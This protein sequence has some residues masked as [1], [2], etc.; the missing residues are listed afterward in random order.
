MRKRIHVVYLPLVVLLL[1]VVSGCGQAAV[2][3]ASQPALLSQTENL[4]PATVAQTQT[5]TQAVPAAAVPAGPQATFAQ[6]WIPWL[7]YV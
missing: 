2:M 7:R 3:P 6:T 1:L 4:Q 5:Q